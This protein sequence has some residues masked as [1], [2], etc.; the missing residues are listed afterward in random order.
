MNL[1]ILEQLLAAR[2]A[3]VE[4]VLATRLDDGTQVLLPDDAAPFA[5][6]DAARAALAQDKTGIQ[7][8]D[9]QRWFLHVHAPP[10]RLLIVGAVHIAQSLAA[11]ATMTGMVVTV[12]DPRRGFAT[13]ERFPGVTLLDQWPDDA[14]ASLKPDRRTAIVVLT[15]DP[16]LDD[17]ALDVALK[18]E[19]FFIGALGSRRS[20]AR[21]L[22]RLAAL[23][24]SA[25][26]LAR[27][28]GPVGLPIG[29]LTAP[30]IALS[31]LAEIVAVR[32]GARSR[33]G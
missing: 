10:H 12:M 24:H 9:G 5:W 4:A 32:R 20:H 22:E 3:G 33:F 8:L 13:E 16:K 28:S 7:E 23:G 17:P 1:V 14:L 25:E 31:T 6:Q 15:H 26:A 19:A 29:A 11:L 21:R 27:I 2:E 18:S 30:E